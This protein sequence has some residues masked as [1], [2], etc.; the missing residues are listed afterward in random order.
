MRYY[1]EKTVII[2]I[3]VIFLFLIAA[4]FSVNADDFGDVKF[5]ASYAQP[6]CEVSGDRRVDLGALRRGEQSFHYYLYVICNPPR[7]FMISALA[8]NSPLLNDYTLLMN[9]GDGGAHTSGWDILVPSLRLIK[10]VT[11]VFDDLCYVLP[12]G[13]PII[14]FSCDINV[15]VNV[16][17]TVIPGDYHATIVFSISYY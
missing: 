9:R 8:V 11:G 16:G 4:V 13:T 1:R 2:H 17:D 7:P 5:K 14:G 15:Y 3:F 6:G 12:G 10:K